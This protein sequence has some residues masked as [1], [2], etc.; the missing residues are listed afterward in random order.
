MRLLNRSKLL[1]QEKQNEISLTIQSYSSARLSR[2]RLSI[3][4][5]DE[6]NGDQNRQRI[7]ILVTAKLQNERNDDGGSLTVSDEPDEQ[8]EILNA[9]NVNDSLQS[10]SADTFIT[11][12]YTPSQ[13]GGKL[14]VHD[15]QMYRIDK[16]I[17]NKTHW[18]CLQ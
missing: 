18:K 1:T 4:S 12:S 14:L 6:R 9:S 5:A 8:V 10:G 7:E 15:G 13:R 2:K 17:K 11:A 16:I 3:S